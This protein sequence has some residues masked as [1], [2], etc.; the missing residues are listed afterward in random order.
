MKKSRI[1]KRGR[2]AAIETEFVGVWLPKH[3]VE[4]LDLAVQ[5]MDSD[6]SKILRSAVREKLGAAR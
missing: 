1:L 4:L 6:R 5:R 2:G 3:L